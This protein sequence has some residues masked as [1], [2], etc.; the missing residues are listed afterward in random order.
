MGFHQELARQELSLLN[1]KAANSNSEKIRAAEV[2][3]V[4]MVGAQSDK[5]EEVAEEYKKDLEE[6]QKGKTSI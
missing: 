3:I 2:Q 1:L 4:R 5:I 6:R